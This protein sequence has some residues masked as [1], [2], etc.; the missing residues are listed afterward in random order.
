MTI[1]VF[2]GLTYEICANVFFFLFKQLNKVVSLYFVYLYPCLGL[3]AEGNDKLWHSHVTAL[4]YSVFRSISSFRNCDSID[5]ILRNGDMYIFITLPNIGNNMNTCY[6]YT[7]PMVRYLLIA[8]TRHFSSTS[9]YVFRMG[10]RSSCIRIWA[11]QYFA[12]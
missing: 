1:I 3:K 4:I 11:T 12:E 7:F 10:S 6:I 5:G 9:L 2:A 8:S